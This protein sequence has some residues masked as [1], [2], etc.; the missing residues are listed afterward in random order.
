MERRIDIY[1]HL[2]QGKVDICLLQESR[3]KDKHLINLKSFNCARDATGVGTLILVKTKYKFTTDFQ[4]F[5]S[6][7]YNPG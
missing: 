4:C 3:L 1:K 7:V 6:C 2:L 5:P